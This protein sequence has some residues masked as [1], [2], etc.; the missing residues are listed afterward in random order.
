MEADGSVRSLDGGRLA[1]RPYNTGDHAV[2]VSLIDC[3]WLA[4]QHPAGLQ[5]PPQALKQLH[6]AEIL[7]V[8]DSGGDVAGVVSFGVRPA[9]GAGLIVQLHGWGNFE[10]IAALL[11][12]ARAQLG[13]RTLYAFTGP[14]TATGIPG[15]PVEHRSVTA[16]ALIAAGFSPA[17]AQRY[18]LRDLTTTPPAPPHYPLANVTIITDPPGW[19]LKLNDIRGRHTATAILRAPTPETADMAVL[20]QLAVRHSHRRQGIATHLLGQCLHHAVQHGA[21]HLTADAPDGDMPATRLLAGAGFLPLDT[22]TIYR[23][24]L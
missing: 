10:A 12:A 5:F 1:V 11:A 20:W 13:Q 6:E 4:G 19:L 2:V 18:F 21:H 16:R 15:L 17:S 8:C 23:R 14:A 3:D 24:Q 7:V 22:L 9:D